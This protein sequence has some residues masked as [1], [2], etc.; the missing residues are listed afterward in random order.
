MKK[1]IQTYYSETLVNLVSLF[2]R[3]GV[4][5]MMLTHGYPKF[6]RLFGE[7]ISFP[8]VLGM[9]ASVSLFLAV[10]SEFFCSILLILGLFTR[11]ASIPLIITMLI[12]VFLIHGDDPFSRQ[13]LG[14]HYIIAYVSILILGSGK[15]SLDYYIMKRNS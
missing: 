14:L 2:L 10:F 13:E 9:S 15:Y 8:E 3:I 4:G 1:L 6:E 12:A 5:A 11:L 7:T